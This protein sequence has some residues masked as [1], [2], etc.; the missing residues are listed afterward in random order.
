VLDYSVRLLLNEIRTNDSL[1]LQDH[2]WLEALEGLLYFLSWLQQNPDQAIRLLV[3]QRS[4]NGLWNLNLVLSRE[5]LLPQL[6]K[7]QY[8]VGFLEE[9]ELFLDLLE[10]TAAQSLICYYQRSTPNG[11]QELRRTLRWTREELDLLDLPDLEEE[12]LLCFLQ[13][14]GKQPGLSEVVE[15]WAAM[16]R[17]AFP[18][19][20]MP[21]LRELLGH[22]R[23]PVL[24]P[25]NPDREVQLRL[26]ELRAQLEFRGQWLLVRMRNIVENRRDAPLYLFL[27]TDLRS[28]LTLLMQYF[29][30]ETKLPHL[31]D[32]AVNSAVE[33]T[34]I[35][36]FKKTLLRWGDYYLLRRAPVLPGSAPQQPVV[37]ET[38]T[39]LLHPAELPPNHG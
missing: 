5:D 12:D 22:L 2:C 21:S 27:F 9:L 36:S 7:A 8:L 25:D 28:F 19:E 3:A 26:L 31:T 15:K 6:K 24:W 33:F 17:T 13:A 38:L 14:L 35:M 16:K 10:P 37:A 18:D 1:K 34:L 39:Y 29:K 4:S 23:V 32:G 11:L 20:L 30:E